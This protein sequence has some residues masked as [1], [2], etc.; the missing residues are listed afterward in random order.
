MHVFIIFKKSI[1][2]SL[3]PLIWFQLVSWHI[4]LFFRHQII[5]STHG[6]VFKYKLVLTPTQLAI[7]SQLYTSLSSG[8]ILFVSSATTYIH[9]DISQIA[10]SFSTMLPES[11]HEML[12][13]ISQV[14][15]G[16]PVPHSFDKMVLSAF[17]DVKKAFYILT[18]ILHPDRNSGLYIDAFQVLGRALRIATR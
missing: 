9:W 18:A 10:I 5:S 7:R 2:N 12:S 14:E 6:I 4:W 8:I 3:W 1:L 16:V 11:K 13:L 17:A 15:D